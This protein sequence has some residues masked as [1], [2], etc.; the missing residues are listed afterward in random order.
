MLKGKTIL[1][2]GAAGGLGSELARTIAVQGGSLILADIDSERA[3]VL[4]AE[5][6]QWATAGAHRL[7]V[8][9][10]ESAL[11]AM[12]FVAERFGA[13]DGLVNAAGIEGAEAPLKDY[14]I[15]RF[16]EVMDVNVRGAL[17]MT[18]AALP[19]MS[20]RGGSIVNIGSV[21]GLRSSPN[22]AAYVV[23]KH[24]LVGLTRATA[25]EGGPL[26]VRANCVS[27]GPLESP[28][29]RAFE[30]N[31]PEG[32]A[33][34]RNWYETHIPAGRYGKPSEVAPLVAFLLSD[35][36]RYI[37]GAHIVVDGGLTASG[38]PAYPIH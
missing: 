9:D 5:V 17:I 28:M 32:A 25:N 30:D 16:Q 36:A 38:R 21:S 3:A 6:E 8:R 35:E 26:G 29:M 11:D 4:S 27:P 31:Y 1:I 14:P 34:V 37:S 10:E 7:D 20:G 24:A 15:D 2:T 13:L 19:L 22:A 33:A 23:S 12:R 18:K